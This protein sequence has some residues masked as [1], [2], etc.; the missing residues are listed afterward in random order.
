MAILHS[1]K[2]AL[3][4]NVKIITGIASY[5]MSGKVFHVPLIHA[6]P[7]FHIKTI[8]ERSRNEV[9][10]RYPEINVV[11]SFE[12]MLKDPE[13]SLVII[14]TPDNTH[15]EFAH[16]AL[17]AG[18]HVV[19]EKPFTLHKGEA[20]DLLNLA[21]RK[22]KVISIFQNRRWDGDFLT[23]QKIIKNELL[24]RLVE[25]EAHFDRFKNHIQA[26]T[27]KEEAASGTGLL[28]NL[29][30]HLI[31]QA[32]VLFGTPEAVTADIRVLRTGGVIDDFF[33]VILHYTDLRVMVKSS[34]LVREPGPRFTLHGT[35]GSFVKYGLDPQEADLK[36]GKI[37]GSPNWGMEREECWGYVNADK[38]GLHFSGKIE[39][40]PGN[41]MEYYN[42]IYD[43]ITL[44]ND[45]SVKPEDAINVITVIEAAYRSSKEHKTINLP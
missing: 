8:V 20:E 43:V 22:Q 33:E 28:Y 23:V 9:K 39:T 31:D 25:Y 24:G 41:Y 26:K 10:N 17:N 4:M 45:L 21:E 37:P 5:G 36:N 40:L 3:G 7:G 14:N 29:G 44:G 18:K 32:L 42:N 15:A 34:Y 35:S 12:E 27:W 2:N 19:V 1:I 16:K 13:I 11:R 38:G 30:S 6:H